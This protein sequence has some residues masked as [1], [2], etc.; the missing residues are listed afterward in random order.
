MRGGSMF[1]YRMAMQCTGA[2]F[3]MPIHAGA[4]AGPCGYFAPTVLLAVERAA[5][6]AEGSKESPSHRAQKRASAHAGILEE[7]AWQR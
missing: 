6:A 7:S 5:P 1:G 2:D 4:A 3:D